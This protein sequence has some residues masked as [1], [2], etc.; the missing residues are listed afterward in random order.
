[1]AAIGLNKEAKA[2]PTCHLG[3]PWGSLEHRD[4]RVFGIVEEGY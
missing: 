4:L 2:S 1:M 3:S